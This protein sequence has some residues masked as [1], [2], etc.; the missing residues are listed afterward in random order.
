M[1]GIA[2]KAKV[3]EALRLKDIKEKDTEAWTPEEVVLEYK[4]EKDGVKV[5]Q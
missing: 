1:D 2:T 4:A 5:K 3:K